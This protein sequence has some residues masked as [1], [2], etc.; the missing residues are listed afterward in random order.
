MTKPD[1]RC[2]FCQDEENEWIYDDWWLREIK[3]FLKWFPS[4][5]YPCSCNF[6]YRPE[7]KDKRD[8]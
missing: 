1:E 6:H 4:A 8:V 5:E 7:R 2:V 3:Y